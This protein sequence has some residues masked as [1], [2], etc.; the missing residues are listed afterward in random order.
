MDEAMMRGGGPVVTM[1]APARA[2]GIALRRFALF[3]PADRK[4]RG[5]LL[6]LFGPGGVR[7][8]IL[9]QIYLARVAQGAARRIALGRPGCRRQTPDEAALLAAV[10]AAGAGDFA[11]AHAALGGLARGEAAEGVVA[12]AAALGEALADAGR[13]LAWSGHAMVL[14]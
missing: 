14:H 7:L 11:G 1:G 13:P 5:E 8:G 9:A 12:V 10:A 4:A 3:G 6:A 2:L